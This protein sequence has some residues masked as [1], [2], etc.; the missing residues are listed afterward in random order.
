MAGWEPDA[1]RNGTSENYTKPEYLNLA[2]GETVS[3]R[4]LDEMPKSVFM[5]KIL[6]NGK[7]YPVTVAREDNERVKKAGHKINKVNIVNVLDRR[8]GKVKIWEFSEERKGEI[9]DTMTRWKK[10]ATEFDIAITRRGL[11]L[12]TRYSVTI[13]PNMEPLSEK[14]LALEKVNLE[15]YY[16]L[17]VD[18]LNALLMGE[19]PKRKEE[20]TP[21]QANPL[22]TQNI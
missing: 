7:R 21:V 16:R 17:N 5:S 13:D 6:V 12:A 4:I 22:E 3:V 20:P 8:D 18:R 11:K 14:E 2:D 10:K 9:H 1:K 19:I 15:E